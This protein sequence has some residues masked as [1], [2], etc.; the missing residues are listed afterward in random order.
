[1]RIPETLSG[2]LRDIAVKLRD[3]E[4]FGADDAEALER[5]L[6]SAKASDAAQPGTMVK[7]SEWESRYPDIASSAHEAGTLH[8]RAWR[9][10]DQ[11]EGPSIAVGIEALLRGDPALPGWLRETDIRGEG[12]RIHAAP[13]PFLPGLSMLCLRIVGPGGDAEW[14]GLFCAGRGVVGDATGVA[15]SAD[16]ADGT[17][18]EATGVA[19]YRYRADLIHQ[20]NQRR[21][22]ALAGH[23]LAYLRYFMR[24]VRSTDGAFRVIDGPALD[25]VQAYLRGCDGDEARQLLAEIGERV[26]PG[27]APPCLIAVHDAGA[28]VYKADLLY[29]GA[30]FRSVLTVAATGEVKM[31]S[32]EQL[33]AA[34]GMLADG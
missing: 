8:W 17:G 21:G 25:A 26:V 16:A 32:D 27:W 13:L 33:T 30:F 11:P 22:L 3:G 31:L 28:L 9:A 4:D 12:A 5:A 18:P 10:G 23:E 20:L 19:A 7:C 1:M 15:E 34:N 2:A 24:I 6:A 14:E 29:D